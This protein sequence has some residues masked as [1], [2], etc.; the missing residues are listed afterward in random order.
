MT[1]VQPVQENGASEAPPIIGECLAIRRAVDVARRFA[2]TSL[3]ILVLGPTGSG[4]ELFAQHI[5]AWSGRRGDLVDVNCAALP[6]ELV[7]GLLFGHRRGVFTGAFE[8]AAGLIESAD[9]GTLFLDEVDTF[10]LEVQPKLLRALEMREV[11]RLGETLKRRVNIRIVSAAQGPV[12]EA[13]TNGRFRLDL[14]QRLAG[15]VIELPSLVER[16]DDL[17]MLARHFAAAHGCAMAPDT[18]G[19]LLAHPWPGNVRELAAAIDRAVGLSDRRDLLPS[20]IIEAIALG[21]PC[22]A[23]SEDVAVEGS[24]PNAAARRRLLDICER[25]GWNATRAA[26]ALALSPATLYRRLQEL[27]ISLREQRRISHVL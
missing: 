8:D 18:G 5:H 15:A 20:T 21:S 14:Y 4:K 7:E 11:R 1:E 10:P 27:G 17:I 6:R 25:H 2:A 22:V 16:G 19:I 12:G 13:I 9:G 3:P 23:S 26:A 24:R